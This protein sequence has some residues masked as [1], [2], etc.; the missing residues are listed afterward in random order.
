MGRRRTERTM[1]EDEIMQNVNQIL[2]IPTTEAGVAMAEAELRREFAKGCPSTHCNRREECASPNDCIR[3]E[4][5]RANAAPVAADGAGQGERRWAIM[6]SQ[7]DLSSL[8]FRDESFAH[9]C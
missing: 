2:G 1:S 5:S 4:K 3:T 6:D 9:E 8:T 7:G